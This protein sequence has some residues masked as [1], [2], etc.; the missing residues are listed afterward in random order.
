MGGIGIVLGL[1]MWGYKVIYRIGHEL[2]KIT[3]SRGFII[4][5]SAALTVLIAS[6]LELPV[7]TTHCQIG[8]IIGCGISDK[9]N[10]IEW[11]LIREIVLSWFVTLPITG[12]ISATLFSFAYYSP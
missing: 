2:T 4:E 6:R 3:A 9:I 11:K 7:S 10:N 5:L 12:L 1:S 8:S